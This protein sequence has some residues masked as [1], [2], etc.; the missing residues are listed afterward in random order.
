MPHEKFE[1][2]N[3]KLEPCPFCG[4]KPEI[5]IFDGVFKEYYVRCVTPDYRCIK[6]E[7][8]DGSLYYVIERWNTRGH[9]Y[10]RLPGWVTASCRDCTYRKV[11]TDENGYET[12]ICTYPPN[13][14]KQCREL[15]RCQ[16]NDERLNKIFKRHI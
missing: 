16:L 4:M 11:E 1:H 8:H 13:E 15:S 6:P 9:Q 5:G 12:S 7:V 3:Y 10:M 2:H 14:G